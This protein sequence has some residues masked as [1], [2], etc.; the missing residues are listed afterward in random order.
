MKSTLGLET[1]ETMLNKR[2]IVKIEGEK[3]GPTVVFFS[4]IHGNET[5]GVLALKETLTKINHTDVNGTVYGVIGNIKA[6]E[7]NQRYVETD[8]N[9]IW[10]TENLK[11][12]KTKKDINSEE[13]ELK[14]LFML[15]SE[16]LKTNKGPFY[17]IDLHTTS[18]GTLPFITINDALIN[19]KF[20][21]QFPVPIV[22]GIE[23]YLNGPLLSYINELGYVSLGFESGQHDD[24]EAVVNA[25]AFVYLTLCFSG[26]I[27]KEN[28]RFFKCFN[29]LN[30]AANNVSNVFEIV[31]LHSIK[32]DD[33]FKMLNGFKS[34]QKI[35]KGNELA[36]SNNIKIKSEYRGRIFMP[37]YQEKGNEGFFIIKKIQPLFLNVSAVLRKIKGDA[38]LVLLP[39]VSWEN[40]EKHVL[41]VNL[42]TAKYLAK[43]IFHL[44]GYRNKQEEGT[45]LK[46]FGRERTSRVEMYN[47]TDWYKKRALFK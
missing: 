40:K 26:V 14:D 18:S 28:S 17:F 34:F 36:T 16:I 27:I 25:K 22:L 13:Q 20:S 9:R 3:T 21:N 15:L 11:K 32:I 39:G 23:E 46:L 1:K 8:L 47:K 44:F 45:H 29:Q 35:K 41:K 19:R 33:S 10:T 42:K 30:S 2:I 5:A 37:L 6:L 12:L 7:Q 24:I 31:H 38:L 4:G 43:Q